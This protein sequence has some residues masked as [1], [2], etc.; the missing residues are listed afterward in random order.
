MSVYWLFIKMMPSFNFF[1]NFTPFQDFLIA[2]F[3]PFQDF[4][5]DIFTPFQ[6]FLVALFSPFR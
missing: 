6:D 1:L 3:T 2:L 5:Q 4:Y